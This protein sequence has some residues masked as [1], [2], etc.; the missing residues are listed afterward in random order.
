[1]LEKAKELKLA[2]LDILVNNGGV[3][4]RSPFVKADM[5][6]AE[7]LI[8]TNF[9]SHVA[10]IKAFLPLIVK[11]KGCIVNVSSEAGLIGAGCRTLY[12]ASKFAIAGFAKALRAELC[13]VGV[14]VINFYPGYI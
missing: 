10:L 13:S 11:S 12:S 9:L 14:K 1:M 6:S 8:N 4:L 2:D 7:T 3:S 5:S